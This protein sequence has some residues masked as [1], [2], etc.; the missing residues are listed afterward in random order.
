V[1]SHHDHASHD[2]DSGGDALAPPAV[3]AGA[4]NQ[5]GEGSG[6]TSN[7]CNLCTSLCSVTSLISTA[8]T[9]PAPLPAASTAFPALAAPVP[10]FL[11]DGQDRPPRSI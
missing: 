11:S 6:A 8:P 1:V 9:V 3:A 7:K 2:H 4:D 10:N 5:H